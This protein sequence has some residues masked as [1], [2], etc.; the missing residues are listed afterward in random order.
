M[1]LWGLGRVAL[2]LF[3]SWRPADWDFEFT[4]VCKVTTHLVVIPVPLQGEWLGWVKE[5]IRVLTLVE[6]GGKVQKG[7]IKKCIHS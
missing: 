5:T 1:G 2:G 7:N 3:S 4:V 6:F